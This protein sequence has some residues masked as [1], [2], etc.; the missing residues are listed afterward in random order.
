MRGAKDVRFHFDHLITHEVCQE[1]GCQS[2]SSALDRG[3]GCPELPGL[4]KVVP[5]TNQVLTRWEGLGPSRQEVAHRCTLYIRHFRNPED[6][7]QGIAS[8]G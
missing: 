4:C 1:A 2:L 8:Q 5:Q 7:W 6:D 3:L